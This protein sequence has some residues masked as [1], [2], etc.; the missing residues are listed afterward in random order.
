MAKKREELS[1]RITYEPNR[2]AAT[3]LLDAYELLAPNPN[4][5]PKSQL[6]SDLQETEIENINDRD[7]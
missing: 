2:F 7:Q 3:H 4:F 5:Q 1:V 6:S